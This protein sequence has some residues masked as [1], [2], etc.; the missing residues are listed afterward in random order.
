MVLVG[1][2]VPVTQETFEAIF[3]AQLANDLVQRLAVEGV[4]VHSKG[5]IADGGKQGGVCVLASRKKWRDA[6]VTLRM[7]LE[8]SKA[9]LC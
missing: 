2:A 9:E 4:V 5:W 8:T 6:R 1:R 7:H 3:T